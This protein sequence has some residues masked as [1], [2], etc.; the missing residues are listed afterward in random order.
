[1]EDT[2]SEKYVLKLED[3]WGKRFKRV[4]PFLDSLALSLGIVNIIEDERVTGIRIVAEILS[5]IPIMN[6]V[7]VSAQGSASLN[8]E[9]KLTKK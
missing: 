6:I 3:P 8:A 2:D 4:Q 1:M 9:A 5:I 7:R